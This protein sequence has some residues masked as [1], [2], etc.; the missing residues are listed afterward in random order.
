MWLRVLRPVFGEQ[1][2]AAWS[3]RL[4]RDAGLQELLERFESIVAFMNRFVVISLFPEN[5]L[6]LTLIIG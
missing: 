5:L 2:G 1:S 4:D 6:K 3:A